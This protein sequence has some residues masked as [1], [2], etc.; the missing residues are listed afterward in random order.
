MNCT[1]VSIMG[2]LKNPMI[3]L[4]MVSMGIFFVMPKMVENSKC[5]HNTPTVLFGPLMYYTI[6]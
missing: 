6:A 5:T 4:A 1:T 2:I 3:L